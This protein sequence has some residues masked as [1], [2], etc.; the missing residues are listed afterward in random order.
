MS[1]TDTNQ[2]DA[3]R[4]AAA[5]LVAHHRQLSGELAAHTVRLQAAAGEDQQLVWRARDVLLDWLRAE[6]LPH[7]AAE[8]AAL[9]PAAAELPAG[10]LLVDGMLAEH[11]VITDLTGELAA[12]GS[13]VTAAAAARALAALF[14]VHLA[15]ENDLILP[16]LLESG[17]V[18]VADLLAGMHA[19][20]GSQSPVP[21]HHSHT[22]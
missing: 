8:E 21:E 7:A 18:S 14:A 17:Q 9:Y 10:R 12:A 1:H 2:T 3:D 6:L 22:T 15:K 19:V 11:R 4:R 13:P 5:A 20:L 16:L